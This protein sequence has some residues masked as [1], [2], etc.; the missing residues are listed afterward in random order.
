MRIFSSPRRPAVRNAVWGSAAAVVLAVVL[1][2]TAGRSSSDITTARLEASLGPTYGRLY[3][4]QMKWQDGSDRLV[5]AV[6]STALCTKG[7]KRVKVGGPGSDWACQVK[8]FGPAGGTVLIT[9]EV[10]VMPNGCYTAEGPPNLVGQSEIKG[11]DWKTHTNPLFAF[12][13]CFDTTA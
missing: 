11:W 8:W 13:G 7:G 5:R 12:D 3:A 1:I 10:D 2:L 4:L 9:Y 6:P